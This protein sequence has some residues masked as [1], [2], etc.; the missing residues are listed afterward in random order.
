MIPRRKEVE[1]AFLRPALI[2]LSQLFYSLSLSLS[3][4]VGN[5]PREREPWEMIIL[6]TRKVEGIVL[7]DFLILDFSRIPETDFL[8]GKC[9]AYE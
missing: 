8:R 2:A 4:S 3:L 9:R 1:R 6:K 7:R 5:L